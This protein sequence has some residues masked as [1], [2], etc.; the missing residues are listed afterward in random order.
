MAC[1]FFLKKAGLRQSSGRQKRLVPAGAG[2][3]HDSSQPCHIDSL[4]NV[5]LARVIL[6][7][8]WVDR[9]RSV[10]L[11]SKRWRRVAIKS[12]WNDFTSFD[13]Q[14]LPVTGGSQRKKVA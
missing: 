3:Y 2:W 6:H 1:E 14:H 10:E 12:G 9:L 4:P 8:P 7:L 5:L 11:V 13:N